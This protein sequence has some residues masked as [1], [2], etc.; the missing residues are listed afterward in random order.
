[1]L[2]FFFYLVSFM[3]TNNLRLTKEFIHL[4]SRIRMVFCPAPDD[5]CPDTDDFCPD[6]DDFCPDP[7]LPRQQDN[8]LIVRYVFFIWPIIIGSKHQK[9]YIEH[10]PKHG[11]E[12]GPQLPYTDPA[13]DF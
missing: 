4:V 12:S 10:A 8:K 1:M 2:G 13:K 9:G 5:F 11:S 6:P 7:D 3:L